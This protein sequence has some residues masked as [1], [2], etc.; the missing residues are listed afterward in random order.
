[1][2]RSERSTPLQP[3]TS[4]R[5]VLGRPLT[6]VLV[7]VISIANAGVFAA[8]FAWPLRPRADIVPT[9]A[10][11]K[12]NV[13]TPSRRLKGDRLA[14]P[15]LTGEWLEQPGSRQD[16]NEMRPQTPEPPILF[17]SAPSMPRDDDEGCEPLVNAQ[18]GSPRSLAELCTAAIE[19]YRKVAAIPRRMNP[20]GA[21]RN[22]RRHAKYV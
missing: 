4:T 21:E 8:S 12:V 3:Q 2:D 1:M 7:S 19:T 14:E 18:T 5:Q 11:Q 13:I 10:I 6:L 17:P 15:N 20:A 22:A 16:K 9:T